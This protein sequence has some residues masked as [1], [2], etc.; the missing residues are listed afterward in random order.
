MT[1]SPPGTNTTEL[2]EAHFGVP[3]SGAV[4]VAV[5]TRLMPGDRV[6][7]RPLRRA[8]PRRRS[9]ARAPG[10]GAGLERVLVIGDEYDAFR[11]AGDGEPEDRL[12]TEDDTISI[13]YTT[14]RPAG[15]GVMYTHRGAYMNALGERTTLGSTRGRSTCGRC[16]CST[17][18]AGASRGRHRR[19][20]QAHLS[21]ESR[22]AGRL[23]A[24]RRR[25]GHAPER[26]TDR[27]RC[28]RRRGGARARTAGTG[29]DRRRGAAGRDLPD[30]SARVRINHV[31]GLTETYGRSRSA[32][33]TPVGR[34]GRRGARAASA[35]G[36]PSSPPTPSASWTRT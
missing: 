35:A 20:C 25:A 26:R 12:E 2:L 15:L 14:G 7:P 30:R 21:A 33:G 23:E 27:P 22:S 32:S 6:H 16:R 8:D 29:D 9:V 17:A 4:L 24:D 3:A 28:R 18:T 31:Y 34:S 36:S 19:R 13:N 1:A 5:N 10:R 11:R